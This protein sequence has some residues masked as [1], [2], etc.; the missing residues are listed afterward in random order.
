VR[1]IALPQIKTA[2]ESWKVQK[3]IICSGADFETLYPEIFDQHP[4]TKCKLQMMKAVAEKKIDIGPTLC[5]GLTLRHYNAFSKCQS[6]SKLDTR[7]DSMDQRYKRHGVHVL[8]A[9]N[10]AGELIIGDSHH[11][12]RT[13]EPFDSEEV[14]EL[15]VD[16]LNTFTSLGKITITERWNGTYP[17]VQGRTTLIIEPEPGVTIVN[18]FGGA[19]MTLSFGVA[20]DVINKL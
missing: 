6:L 12:G 16:Y 5:A 4:V 14:N 10:D 1:E 9:Q 20:E 15:I 13:V 8:L 11:Y 3:V 7:Y 19:G 17:K 18:G 2:R